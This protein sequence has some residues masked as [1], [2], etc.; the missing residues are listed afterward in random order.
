MADRDRTPA[1]EN[2]RPRVDP[3]LKTLELAHA[4]E[5]QQLRREYLRICSSR[6]Q[7][8]VQLKRQYE[9]GEIM[10]DRKRS[11]VRRTLNALTGAQQRAIAKRRE[12]YQKAREKLTKAH[13]EERRKHQLRTKLV[14]QRQNDERQRLTDQLAEK[15]RREERVPPSLRQSFTQSRGYIAGEHR[16]NDEQRQRQRDHGRTRLRDSF[17]RDRDDIT[18]GGRER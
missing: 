15:S 5:L 11:A 8:R 7:E 6:R 10:H 4:G 14:T 18:E 2:E 13:W 16:A 9:A 1:N 12:E 3:Q 17:S